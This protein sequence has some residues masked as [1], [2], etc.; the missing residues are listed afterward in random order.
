MIPI[1]WISNTL[2]LELIIT[3]SS[4]ITLM[5]P[6]PSTRVWVQMPRGANQKS[7]R[8]LNVWHQQ[9]SPY[10]NSY[11]G[12]NHH[13]CEASPK[14]MQTTQKSS[15]FSALPR[16]LIYLLYPAL[17]FSH[18]LLLLFSK[19]NATLTQAINKNKAGRK[20]YFRPA[21]NDSLAIKSDPCIQLRGWWSSLQGKS[22]A[23]HFCCWQEAEMQRKDVFRMMS[24]V[25]DGWK[26]PLVKVV[27]GNIT[28]VR[29]VFPAP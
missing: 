6:V 20:S 15:V 10:I 18:F 22:P 11:P 8:N 9:T 12:K 26:K 28:S 21:R 5:C 1:L 3:T 24:F 16:F 2:E 23:R 19:C 13:K 4:A 29:L 25:A 14:V 7:W 27:L 17:P